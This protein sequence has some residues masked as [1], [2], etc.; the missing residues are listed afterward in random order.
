VGPNAPRIDEKHSRSYSDGSKHPKWT[1]GDENADDGDSIVLNMFS[2][3]NS[4]NPII[5]NEATA[6]DLYKLCND[7]LIKRSFDDI[8]YWEPRLAR[9]WDKAMICRGIAAKKNARELA[10]LLNAQWNSPPIAR[11]FR[12]RSR[13]RIR[14][15]SAHRI[16]RRYGRLPRRGRLKYWDRMRSKRSSGSTSFSKAT[17]LPM[18]LS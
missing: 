10:A 13:G 14:R 15:D 11:N 18:G 2:E 8:K 7:F 4:L 17:S 1:R 3:P 16:E 9:A 12:L 5:D 6:S